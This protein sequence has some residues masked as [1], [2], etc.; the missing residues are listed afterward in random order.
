MNGARPARYDIAEHADHV[1]VRGVSRGR[2]AEA[3]DLLDRVRALQ[4]DHAA[5]TRETLVRTLMAGNVPL[6]PPATV[7]QA[8]RLA[9][10]RDALLASGVLTQSS[11]SQL[12]G[13]S[14]PSSTRTWLARRKQ[15]RALFTVS[16]GGRTLIPAFQ[17]DEHGEPRPELQPI[18][19]VLL[20]AGVHGW[21]LWT[22]LTSPT[23]L[24]SGEVPERLARTAGQRVLRA[25]QRFAVT[26][27]A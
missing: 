10:H 9:G 6:T 22:W 14:R 11:L 12:R 2:V 27:A 1:E 7:A 3:L 20:D 13:D 8:Q 5:D 25:A 16:H 15:A 4:A 18:L 17:L 23:S 21:T 26:A 19:A 24:L